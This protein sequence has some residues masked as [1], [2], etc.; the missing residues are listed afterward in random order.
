M[1]FFQRLLDKRIERFG[2]GIA[3]TL[4]ASFVELENHHQGEKRTQS[5]LAGQAL[6]TRPQWRKVDDS[7]FWYEL[8]PK[9]KGYREVEGEDWMNGVVKLE[10][11]TTLQNVIDSVIRIELHWFVA[12]EHET[13][14]RSRMIDLAITAA[15]EIGC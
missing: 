2:Q 8:G 11:S 12:Q 10:N 1:G 6:S 9:A 4:K 3:R 5:W 13:E 15:R 7:E 14:E